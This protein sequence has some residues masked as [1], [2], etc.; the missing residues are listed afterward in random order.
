MKVKPLALAALCALTLAACEGGT[1]GKSEVASR[2]DNS[3]QAS[4]YPNQTPELNRLI[5]R[6]ATF[7]GVPPDLVHRVVIRESRYQP[8]ARNGPYYGLMQILPQ[9]ARTMGHRG[10]PG[11]LLDA[12]TNL[13]YAVK[14][15]RGAWLVSDGNRDEA[16]GWYARGYYYEAKRLGLL[17]ETGLR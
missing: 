9:T 7:Y 6:Y 2:L 4:V 17:E 12:E 15:L 8:G 16:V 10:A 5:D 1:S 14:Y 11:E 13:K 3:R